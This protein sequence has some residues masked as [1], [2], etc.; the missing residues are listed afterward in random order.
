VLEELGDRI[1]SDHLLSPKDYP[2]FSVY[3]ERLSNKRTDPNELLAVSQAMLSDLRKIYWRKLEGSILNAVSVS[4]NKREIISLAT[5]FVTE[6]ELV[7]FNRSYVYYKTQH[8]FFKEHS[9]P[10]IINR[11][12]QV[13]DFLS[14]FYQDVPEWLIVLRGDLK[15]ETMLDH[16]ESFGLSITKEPPETLPPNIGIQNWDVL[17]NNNAF[18]LYITIDGIEQRDPVS[19][20]EHASHRVEIMADVF[21]FLSH[22]VCP[23]I[24]EDALILNKNTNIATVLKPAPDP[25]KKG[26]QRQEIQ[27]DDLSRM[28][29]ILSGNLFS[30]R[31]TYLFTKSIDYHR[32]ALESKTPENQLLDLWASLEGFLPAPS[33]DSI[34]IRHYVAALSPSLVLTY[35]EK[36]FDYIRDSIFHGGTRIREIVEQADV[37]GNFFEKT[38]AIIVAV[39][40]LR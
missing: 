25:M 24:G 30:S 1:K 32:A 27:N 37:A 13:T 16:A 19:A 17:G 7:G 3:F 23:D 28:I 10:R 4:K 6:A 35:P 40:R 9:E 20:R 12:E 5:A 22:T 31:A 26:S 8:F 11:P 14:E 36:V 34:R 38:I 29:E 21:S 2:V 33:E 18:P 39:F 15:F